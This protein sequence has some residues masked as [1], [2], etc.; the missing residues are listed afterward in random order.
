L[1]AFLMDTIIVY[2]CMLRATSYSTYA[3]VDE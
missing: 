3:S 2:K 1:I